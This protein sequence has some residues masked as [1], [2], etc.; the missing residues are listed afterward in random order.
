LAESLYERVI[1]LG[2]AKKGTQALYWAYDPE[3]ARRC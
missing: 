3:E 1:E 2:G